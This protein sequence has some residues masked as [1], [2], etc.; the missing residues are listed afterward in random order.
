MAPNAN[1]RSGGQGGFAPGRGKGKSKAQQ[2]GI[3]SGSSDKAVPLLCF[4]ANNNW[5]QFKER[6]ATACLEKYGDLARLIESETYYEPE[7]VDKAQFE[8][9]ETDEVIKTL[10]IEEIK[11]RAKIIRQM[12]ENRA[13]MYAYIILKLSKESLDEFKHHEDFELIKRNLSAL[14]LWVMLREIHAVNN[15]TTNL[16]ILKKEAFEKNAACK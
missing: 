1:R 5:L 13:K 7:P 4:G 8:G 9:W 14:G 16:L 3:T 15:S 11:A 12:K 6:M 10:Y 2:Y